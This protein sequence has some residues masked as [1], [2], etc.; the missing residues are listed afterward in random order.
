MTAPRLR[1]GWP[2]RIYDL[3]ARPGKIYGYFCTQ[4]GDD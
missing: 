4:S 1:A 3:H 2:I